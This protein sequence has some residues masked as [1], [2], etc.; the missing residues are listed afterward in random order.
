M[1][2][3]KGLTLVEVLASLT[4]F[5]LICGLFYGVLH[6]VFK[7][8]KS[9]QQKISAQQEANY[10]LSTWTTMHQQSTEYTISRIND[11]TL[12]LIDHTNPSH[13]VQLGN[14]NHLLFI[15][16]SYGEQK[17]NKRLTYPISPAS[18]REIYLKHTKGNTQTT[19]FTFGDK[20]EVSLTG[21]DAKTTIQV[22]LTAV[23]KENNSDNF[24]IATTISRMTK[25]KEV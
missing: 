9:I 19:T 7:T 12:Q 3:E 14:N 15:T 24:T 20:Q 2:S 21:K 22:E 6:N 4:L 23:N 17:H 10:I 13:N 5:M 16:I 11:T 8:N 1:K 18:D 25:A